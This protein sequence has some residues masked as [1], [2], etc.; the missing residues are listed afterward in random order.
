MKSASLLRSK[1]K[2]HF[3]REV[4]NVSLTTN[5]FVNTRLR[6]RSPTT[7]WQRPLFWRDERHKQGNNGILVEGK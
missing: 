4:A 5:I 1:K 7:V 6:F 3:V 2:G